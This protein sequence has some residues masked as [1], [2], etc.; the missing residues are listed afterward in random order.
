MAKRSK[1]VDDAIKRCWAKLAAAAFKKAVVKVE[2][3]DFADA[4]NVMT[5][6]EDW[7]ERAG[8]QA[9]RWHF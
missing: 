1:T 8:A 9:T 2:L 5:Y 4:E 3:N 6:V 7:A